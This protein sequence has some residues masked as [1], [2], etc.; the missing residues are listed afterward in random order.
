MDEGKI[1]KQKLAL[2]GDCFK[3]VVRKVRFIH[4]FNPSNYFDSIRHLKQ[5]ND[6][7]VSLHISMNKLSI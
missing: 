7:R 4:H 3:T 6:G 5:V 1:Y 2:L